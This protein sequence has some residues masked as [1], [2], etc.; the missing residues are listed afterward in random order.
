LPGTVRSTPSV[1]A[2]T[3]SPRL[4]AVFGVEQSDAKSST[5]S[6]ANG[7]DG[8][9]GEPENQDF[10]RASAAD[11]GTAHM[12]SS[13]DALSTIRGEPGS[14][15]AEGLLRRTIALEEDTMEDENTGKIINATNTIRATNA[16]IRVNELRFVR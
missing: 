6:L 8:E 3:V 7:I 9:D 1:L 12:D 15:L 14:A 10:V 16:A 13:F 5:V 4:K 2:Q 11:P